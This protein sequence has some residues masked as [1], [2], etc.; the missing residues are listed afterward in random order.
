MFQIGLAYRLDALAVLLG[1]NLGDMFSIGYSVDVSSGA[2][3]KSNMKPTH[4]IM[5]SYR[6]QLIK[7]YSYTT[8]R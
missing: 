3:A 4:E 5:L 1:F 2:L 7:T 8:Y 6:T